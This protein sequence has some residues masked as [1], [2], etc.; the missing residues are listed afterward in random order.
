MFPRILPSSVLLAVL[1]TT[2][3]A[4]ARD[5]SEPWLQV[6][7]P[8]FVVVTNGNEKQGRHVA[9]QFER[10]RSV[11]HT[12]FPKAQLDLGSPIVVIAVKEDK[13]FRALEPEAYLAKGSLKLGGLF[14]RAPDKNY[15]L[16]R[17]EAEGEHPYSII[18]HEYTHLIMTKAVEFL[19][20][21]LNEG[22]AE[23]YQNTE[24][25]EKETILGE[26]SRD[27][28]IWLRQNRLL[29]LQTLLTVDATSPYYHEENKGSIFYAE[30]WALTHYLQI[31]DFQHN[32][33]RVGDYLKLM[34]QHVDSVTAATQAFG[35]L[36][37]LQDQLERYIRQAAF[38]D[39]KLKATTEVDDSAFKIQ[40]LPTTQADAVRADFLAYNERTADAQALLDAVLKED[41]NNVSAHETKGFLAFRQHNLDEAKK[42][43]AQA[44]ELDSKSYLA[45]YYFAA[46][47]MND[48]HDAG[49]QDQDQIEKSLRAAIALN[50]SFAPAFDRLAIYLAMQH[51]NLE[52]AR[53]MAL[54]AISL[55]PGTIGYRI[56]IANIFMEMEKPQNAIGVLQAAEK[57]ATTP[58]D[59]VLVE[60]ALMHAREYAEQQQRF[61]EQKQRFEQAKADGA[62]VSVSESTGPPIRLKRR[63]EFVAKGPHRFVT[64]VLKGVHC[65]NPA[66][67]LTVNANGKLVAVHAENYYAIPFTALG[68]TPSNDLNP[69]HDL[70]NRPAKVE[71]VESA[72]PDVTA[73]L[74]SIEIHK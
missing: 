22:L 8:H 7:T 2:W 13:D 3:P 47:S 57:I 52:E 74:I 4:A 51:K 49:G 20:L 29:P 63:S 58:Q 62:A 23:F 70:E 40:P 5:K 16:M 43:Y 33:Q 25:R 19:P 30:S 54:N 68:F 44:V 65:D 64:G 48:S 71:Y 6:S 34:S 18:Y 10:M 17:L 27:D 21:W 46:I 12:A 61:A 69:C 31:D 59:S 66:I 39:L 26:P 50:P 9:D 36:K 55:E 24:I 45:H 1:L 14:L 41:P 11:F 72:N 67:D 28:I 35:D 32:R 56:N 37:Q 42:W 53:M 38:T 60:N 73:Q 15:V